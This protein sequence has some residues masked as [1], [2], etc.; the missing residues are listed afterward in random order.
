MV[1]NDTV[2]RRT[3]LKASAGTVAASGFAGMA[4]AASYDA[5]VAFVGTSSFHD[6]Y[7]TK[8]GDIRDYCNNVWESDINDSSDTYE[9]YFALYTDSDVEIPES[10]LDS[11]STLSDRLKAADSWLDSN[12]SPYD[13]YDGVVI[14]D[15]WGGDSGVWGVAFQDGAYCTDDK[16]ALADAYHEDNNNLQEYQDEGTE[17][18]AAH[19]ILHLFNGEHEL[20]Y[21]DSYDDATLM[22]GDSSIDHTCNNTD[23]YADDVIQA[24]SSCNVDRV[25]NHLDNSG[26]NCTRS[27]GGGGGGEIK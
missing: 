23:D 3:V 12:W 25:R 27:S 8:L 26:E 15:Y 4:S 6:Q 24:Y 13:D 22:W 7:S 19:E 11:A 10:A 1:S 2:T 20:G 5:W 9:P 14:G 21:V 18:V 16:S 17:G